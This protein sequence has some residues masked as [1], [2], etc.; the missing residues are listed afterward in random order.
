M[1]EASTQIT[2]T[3]RIKKLPNLPKPE[4][5]RIFAVANQKGGVGK[6]TST[7]NLAAAM[8]LSGLHV[9]VVD[10]DPQGNAST[11]LAIGHPVGTPD[12]YSV[13]VEGKPLSAIV[14]SCPTIP[15]LFVAPAT[16][17]LAGAEIELVS[18]VAREYRLARAIDGYIAEHK[19]KHG[20]QIDYVLIDCPPSLGLLTLNALVAAKE[21]LIP[22]Q[23]EYYALEGVGQ[24]IANVELVREHLNPLLDVST[25]LMTMFNSTTKLSQQVVEEVRSHFGDRV[26]TAVVPR[27]VRLSEAPS[28]SQTIFTYDGSSI[29]AQSY[30]AAATEITNKIIGTK[31]D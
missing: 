19:T 30:L 28:Y 16:V 21:V 25:I 10:I 8:A 14:Q 1:S 24:L 31:H 18:V 26:L 3:V 20:R 4:Q 11:A 17:D 7:V 15:G 22:I 2:P 27:A 29:G 9:L 13:L 6:T 5:T 12:V 23:C